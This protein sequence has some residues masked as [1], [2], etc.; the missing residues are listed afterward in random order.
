MPPTQMIRGGCVS[1]RRMC[2]TVPIHPITIAGRSNSRHCNTGCWR[3][4]PPLAR[5]VMENLYVYGPHGGAPMSEDMPMRGQ[6]SRSSTRVQMTKE[7]FAAH[8]SGKLRA[9]SVRA[10]DLLGPY[11]SESLAGLGLANEVTGVPQALIGGTA[12][13]AVIGLAQW[14]VLRQRLPLTPWWIV[15]T[16]GGTAIGLALG[17]GLLGI[18]T[19]GITLP[20]RGLVTDAGIGLAQFLLLRTV[21]DRAPIWPIVVTLGWAIGWIVTRAAGVDLTPNFT[22]FGSTGAWAFQLLTGLTLVWILRRR[23]MVAGI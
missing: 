4:P 11:V 2:I 17:V 1:G 5:S 14:L 9:V 21:T 8:A 18:E 7:L 23:Q 6:G 20:L 16:A 13:G 3:V 19:S 22:V 12:T 10:S 15:A